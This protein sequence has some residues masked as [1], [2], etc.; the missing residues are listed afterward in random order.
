MTR[1]K[2]PPT[3]IVLEVYYM[4]KV[5]PLKVSPDR[6]VNSAFH[7]WRTP[8]SGSSEVGCFRLKPGTDYLQRELEFQ[9]LGPIALKDSHLGDYLTRELETFKV[10]FDDEGGVELRLGP[11]Q[12]LAPIASRVAFSYK[13]LLKQ[14]REETKNEDKHG[15]QKQ[16]A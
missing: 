15:D 7:H 12:P 4:N 8:Y 2:P 10:K 9:P 6:G 3:P 14:K 16:R 13:K 5:C 1:P 11:N